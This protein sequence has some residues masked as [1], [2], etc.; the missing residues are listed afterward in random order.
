MTKHPSVDWVDIGAATGRADRPVAEDAIDR[1]YAAAGLPAPS[2]KLWVDSPR[3]GL[4]AACLFGRALGEARTDLRIQP[5]KQAYRLTRGSYEFEGTGKDSTSVWGLPAVGYLREA[6]RQALNLDIR[7]SG[8]QD[9]KPRLWALLWESARR[10]L[11]SQGLDGAWERISMAGVIPAGV[12]RTAELSRWIWRCGYGHH[13]ADA[14]SQLGVVRDRL[15]AIQA[16][17]D[18]ARSCGWW[19]PFDEAC[20]LA[21]RPIY[22]AQDPLGRLHDSTR[23]AVEYPDAWGSHA[24]HGRPV[25]KRVI[26]A[27]ETLR[28]EDV[29]AEEDPEMRKLLLARMTLLRFMKLARS[30]VIHRDRGRALLAVNQPHGPPVTA[31]QVVCASTGKEYL[32]RV[33]PYMITCAAAVA[34]TFGMD[35]TVYSPV[36]ET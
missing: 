8:I 35:P 16:L 25:D 4:F 21:E 6:V 28:P 23:A 11:R 15:P 27:P 7:R 26:E 29:F 32:L 2:V 36:I 33:P 14:M 24:W 31:V 19:W 17:C 1:V 3:E 22:L 30:R 10:R 34:W 18:L 20:I 9:D 5:M 13:D 12:P